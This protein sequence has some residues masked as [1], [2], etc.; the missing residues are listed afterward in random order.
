MTFTPYAL[1][2]V[3]LPLRSCGSAAEWAV[4]N[5][6]VYALQSVVAL[7]AHIKTTI[8]E[9]QGLYPN[10]V[11]VSVNNADYVLSGAFEE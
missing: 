9:A 1:H 4:C 7:A 3:E 10:S 11:D 2:T 6:H 8:D 5:I